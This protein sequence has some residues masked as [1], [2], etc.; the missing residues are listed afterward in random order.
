MSLLDLIK[1]KLGDDADLSEFQSAFDKEAEAIANSKVQGLTT[2]RDDLLNQVKNLKKNQM[3]DDV[4][5]DAYN[6][7][8]TEK[9]AL[10]IEKAEAD[11]ARLAAAGEWDRLKSDMNTTHSEE[12]LNVN[13]KFND[14]VGTLQKALDHE[15]IT[16]ALM[17]VINDEQGNS[18]LLLPHLTPHLKT[19]Q[20]K[21]TGKYSTIVIDND[22]NTRMNTSNGEPYSIKDL[23]TEF[24]ANEVF[25][26]AFPM[27]NSGTG[28]TPNVG[29]NGSFG[30]I[31][32]WMSKTKNV[33]LQAKIQKENAE[34]AGQ[35]RKQA[36]VA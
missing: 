36:G 8:L 22:G 2:K 12:L 29:G 18:T 3:P 11:E 27:Q 19:V 21:E 26:G 30:Q 20:D 33:T 14:Q 7:F 25:A 32:P 10:A 13:N 28:N 17:S 5:M 6:T 9:E 1:E 15:L 34:L 16:N 4:D 35:L 23:V 31:N 24:K